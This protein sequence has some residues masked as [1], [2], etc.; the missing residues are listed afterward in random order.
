MFVSF[1]IIIALVIV[2]V[3]SFFRTEQ[4]QPTAV[5]NQEHQQTQDRLPIGS[6]GIGSEQHPAGGEPQESKAKDATGAPE[7]NRPLAA[8]DVDEHKVMNTRAKRMTNLDGEAYQH[9]LLKAYTQMY[10]NLIMS[11]QE[12]CIVQQSTG[13]EVAV[14]AYVR[15]F[16]KWSLEPLNLML[17]ILFAKTFILNIIQFNFDNS[18][19]LIF[20]FMKSGGASASDREIS[21]TISTLILTKFAS[22]RTMEPQHA[23]LCGI[24]YLDNTGV[25]VLQP[26]EVVRQPDGRYKFI[27]QT[28]PQS[29]IPTR[30]EHRVDSHGSFHEDLSTLV[31]MTA[32]K[33]EIAKFDAFLNVQQQRRK[34]GLPLRNQTL[35][36]VFYGNPGTGKT[37]VA[38]ILG[39]IMNAYGLLK[40]GH[41][42]ETDRAGLV[43][44]YLGQTAGKTDAK[45]REAL[46]G[47]LFI[48]EAYTL[49]RG[50]QQDSYG[51]EAIDI[52]LKRMED[53]RDRLA[54]VVA[55]YPGPMKQF[56]TSNPGLESRFTR[57]M[58]FEDYTPEELYQ[59]FERFATSEH[60][61][62]TPEAQQ[63]LRD[64][65][66]K[67]YQARSERFGNGRYVR[68]VFE[69]VINRQ[70]LRLT[71][72]MR[73]SSED[74]LRT[75]IAEDIPPVA[76]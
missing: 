53:H 25:P 27:S 60:Y 74:E 47:V 48:D 65:F 44:D 30:D 1:T 52:L 64:L 50:H 2:V 43:A 72:L 61:I 46:D 20:Q 19:A 18:P 66:G 9:E 23:D 12:L 32:V 58:H 8:N 36:F 75:I 22:Y 4:G 15:L 13:T 24:A 68:N 76:G 59:I 38:R 35:H 34:S 55:G 57:F 39:K 67:A 45:L 11:V 17:I 10:F 41:V 70:A 5:L 6:P 51:Q 26:G 29:G 63:L 54:V 33:E 21:A 73:P 40:R 56:L 49:A 42:V 7:D 37:T 71:S 28:F 69:E 31:G 3:S 16:G 14:D 62:V